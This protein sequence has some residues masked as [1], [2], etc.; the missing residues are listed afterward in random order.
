M[1]VQSRGMGR[2]GSRSL[3]KMRGL[4]GRGLGLVS[5]IVNGNNILSAGPTYS[6]PSSF[7]TF[8]PTS[9]RAPI[10][11]PIGPALPVSN[12]PAQQWGS[13]YGWG[14]QFSNSGQN[15]NLPTTQNNLA[16]LT[17]LYQSNPASL[18]AQQWAQLQAA[19]VIAS[20]VPYSD[21][22]LVTPSGALAS[23]GSSAIDPATGV[24]YA[25]ELAAAQSGATSS[26]ASSVI[27]YDPTTGSTT[28]FGVDWYWIAGGL[29]AVLLLSQ[30][31]GR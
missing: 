17:L 25:T 29:A 27:G 7:R 31:R 19:G 1:L 24:P 6:T 28:I 8:R 2:L 23:P 13:G 20:T 15:P 14:S 4:R 10:I 3:G 21:A 18:T 26:A 22:S 11:Q 12:P 16:Q 5:T 9:P 30:K